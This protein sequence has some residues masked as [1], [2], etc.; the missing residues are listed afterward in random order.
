MWAAYKDAYIA[1]CAKSQRRAV[2]GGLASGGIWT[3]FRMYDFDWR[4]RFR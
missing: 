1:K 2:T 3:V 4:R